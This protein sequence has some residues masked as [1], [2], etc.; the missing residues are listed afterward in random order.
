M[1]TSIFLRWSIP[2]KSFGF[3]KTQ[4][5]VHYQRELAPPKSWLGA[6]PKSWRNETPENA[7][8]LKGIYIS[9]KKLGIVQLP[10]KKTS[11][12]RNPSST[13]FEGSES[14]RFYPAPQKTARF[15]H[16]NPPPLPRPYTGSQRIRLLPRQME[17]NREI[18][19]ANLL[20]YE[21]WLKKTPQCRKWNCSW[22]RDPLVSGILVNIKHL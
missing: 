14:Q 15:I 11:G 1:Q 7:F 10:Y 5:I 8:L 22:V 19:G 4:A 17:S 16:Y 18:P 13:K 9:K 21:V 6:T 12:G 3:E 2:K 20:T